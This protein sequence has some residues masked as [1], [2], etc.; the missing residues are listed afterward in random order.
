MG[1]KPVRV[2]LERV[3]A[4]I[5]LELE[6]RKLTEKWLYE[7]IGMSKNGYREMWDRGSVKAT[8]LQDIADA[9]GITLDHLLTGDPNGT[10]G[11]AEP[12]ATYGRPRYLEERVADLERRIQEIEVRKA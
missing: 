10:D 3:R 12:L 9:F 6:R 5:A 8:A 2:D 1:K 4:T 7:R 11:V